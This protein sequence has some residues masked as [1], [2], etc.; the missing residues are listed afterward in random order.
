VL[1]RKQRRLAVDA[2]FRSRFDADTSA[3]FALFGRVISRGSRCRFGSIA[4]RPRKPRVRPFEQLGW[5]ID[6]S[7]SKILIFGATAP[8]RHSRQSRRCYLEAM[9]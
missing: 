8:R 4:N 9:L 5:A 3:G 1:A 6:R 2:C 7:P